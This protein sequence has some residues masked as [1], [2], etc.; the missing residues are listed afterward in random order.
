MTTGSVIESKAILRAL[1]QLKKALIDTSSIIYVQKAGYFDVLAGTIQLYS[2]PEVVS[3]SKTHVAGVT[4]IHPS[5]SP[6]LSTDQKL[7]SCALENKLAMISEDKRIL[8][9]MRRAQ[10]PYYNALMMLNF[11]LFTKKIDDDGYRRYYSALENIAR[12]SEAVWEFGRLIYAAVKSKMDFET[13][14]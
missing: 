1:E 8:R 9:A 10:A 4:L 6:S 2:I 14:I 3:E 13:P 5:E 12:Y 7:V 11:L